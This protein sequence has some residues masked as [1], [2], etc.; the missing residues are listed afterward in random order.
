M[1]Q[2]NTIAER[3]QHAVAPVLAHSGFE[4]VWVE[5]V[6]KSKV[7]RLYIDKPEGVTLEDCSAVSH[8]V[9]DI[10]DAEGTVEQAE[11]AQHG[12]GV[13]AADAVA[14]GAPE[15]IS[16][17]VLE[18]IRGHYTLEVSSPGLDRPLVR[19][20][21]FARFVG[22]SVVLTLAAPLE[23]GRRKLTGTLVRASADGICLA[24]PDEGEQEWPYAM[25]GRARLVPEF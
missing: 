13:S 24:P 4:L 17:E 22:R 10:L 25:I 18:A 19:P 9:S 5:F 2:G 15:L 7:L 1:Q 14:A 8:R 3:V 16:S 20:E 6:A 21:H 23:G 12:A 11:S